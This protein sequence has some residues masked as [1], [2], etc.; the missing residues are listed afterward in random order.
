MKKI[1]AL[2]ILT[3]V[4]LGCEQTLNVT[5]PYVGDRFVLYAELSPN[6]VAEVKVERTYPPTGQ[7]SLDTEYLNKTNVELYEEGNFVETFIRKGISNRFVSGSSFK[8]KVGKSYYFRVTAEG[9]EEAISEPQTI[10]ANL[11]IINAQ[12][13]DEEVTYRLNKSTPMKL[14]VITLPPPLKLGENFKLSLNSYYKNYLTST[15][16][17]PTVA[18]SEFG[19]PC[20][21]YYDLYKSACFD[22][23]Q[24]ELKFFVESEGIVQ[25]NLDHFDPNSLGNQK[26]TSVRIEAASVSDFYK[27]FYINSNPPEGI[28]KAFQPIQATVT[29]VKGG[30]GAVLAKN[31]TVI[32]VKVP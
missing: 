26:I 7:Y 20:Y 2:F 12:F 31:E 25:D 29:N 13:S 22:K 5:L 9:F 27:E 18:I 19:S 1:I 30:Y 28:F 15:N 32:N 21:L 16:I 17:V 24:N 8:P 14:L 10:P 3:A 6:T 4:L 23:A 11:A